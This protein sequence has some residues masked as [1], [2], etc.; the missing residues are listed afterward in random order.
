MSADCKLKKSREQSTLLG[1][2]ASLALSGVSL[3]QGQHCTDVVF[4][5]LD[6]AGPCKLPGAPLHRSLGGRAADGKEACPQAH[7]ADLL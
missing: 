1:Q 6:P 2:P 5:L 3:A 4:L 7:P